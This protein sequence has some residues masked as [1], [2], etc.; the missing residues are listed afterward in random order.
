MDEAILQIGAPVKCKLCDTTG[1]VKPQT[2]YDGWYKSRL[3]RNNWRKR[4]FCP[5]EHAQIGKDMDTNFY[6]R[7]ATPTT[8]PATAV[9]DTTEELYKLLD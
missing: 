5:G 1:R 2:D 7:Y 6:E 9:E 8:T 3:L 4:W